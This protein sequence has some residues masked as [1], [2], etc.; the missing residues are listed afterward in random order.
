MAD[1]KRSRERERERERESIDDV[2]C[3]LLLYKIMKPSP[4][5]D[6]SIM[7]WHH[8]TVPALLLQWT[9]RG[10]VGAVGPSATL[11]VASEWRPGSVNVTTRPQCM[12]ESH[13][14]GRTRATNRA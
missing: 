14:T 7:F 10:A 2:P 1:G 11:A 5:T 8:N 9:V 12:E 13:V 6:L 4:A 3:P